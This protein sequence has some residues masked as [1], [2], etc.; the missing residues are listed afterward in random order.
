MSAA[1]ARVGVDVDHDEQFRVVEPCDGG[2]DDG[3]ADADY[4]ECDTRHHPCGG[5]FQ[6]HFT[7]AEKKVFKS[8][9]RPA[10]DKLVAEY[11]A[12]G[13]KVILDKLFAIRE[14]TLWV[15]ARK[16][17]WLDNMDDMFGEFCTR[18]L[19]CV[20]KYEYAAK[21][22]PVR[23]QD[24]TIVY[25]GGRNVTQKDGTVVNV[26]GK[27]KTVF[28]RTP[29]N[30]YM[31]TALRNKVWNIIK[32][33]HGKNSIDSNG[34]PIVET[35]LSL[36]YEYG[37]DDPTTLCEMISNTDGDSV[38]GA[39][40]VG[41]IIDQIA[42]EDAELKAAMSIFAATP[43]MRRL[44]TACGMRKGVFAVPERDRRILSSGGRRAEVHIKALIAATGVYPKGFRVVSHEMRG[45]EVRFEVYAKNPRVVRK[46]VK[47]LESVKSR[48]RQ[49]EDFSVVQK[50]LACAAV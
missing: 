11:Q 28:K 33:R 50:S 45:N 17:A 1:L 38:V 22:R 43:D 5:Q 40:A 36:D 42:G 31:F 37:D 24:G 29:F 14:P 8:V 7:W 2:D 49:T 35:M 30:T 34:R 15:W 46:L 20:N 44:S 3:C 47:A 21:L 27:M 6:P 23:N 39:V 16:F 48:I 9:D 26:G 13:D 4:D 32:K 25:E 19:N 41:D 10:E 18:W 12:T